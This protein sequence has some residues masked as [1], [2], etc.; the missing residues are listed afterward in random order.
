VRLRFQYTPDTEAPAE[1]NI[2]LP[3]RRLLCMAENCSSTLH[4][5]YTPRG[6]QIR[7]ALAWSKY[8]NESIELFGATTDIVFMSHHWPRFGNAAVVRFLAEQRDTYRWIHDETMRRANHGETASEIA[9]TLGPPPGLEDRAHIR[10]YYGTLS[11]NAKAVYQRYLG[12]FDANP[13]HLHPLPPVEAASRYVEFMGGIDA[14]VEKVQGSIAAG[15]YRWAAQVLDHAVFAAPD[16]TD[17]KLLQADV[18]E[19]LGY[20]AESGP[21]RDFYLTGAQELRHGAPHLGGSMA[22]SVDVLRAMTTEMLVDLIAVRLDGAAA[23]PVMVNLTITDRRDIGVVGIDHGA[24]R[25]TA[26]RHDAGAT[27]ALAVT[28]LGLARLASGQTSLDELGDEAT[29]SGD[30][31]ALDALIASLDRFDA[32]FA[33]VTP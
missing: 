24:V 26:G 25:F 16:R 13:A 15:E 8:I 23:A 5:V 33:I 21:W 10:G 3:D 18:L 31:A 19:Q 4:N 9:E 6:A 29:V 27:V 12:W 17:V 28:H 30:R 32:S 11:H 20:R 14:V 2:D 1:M 22:S 7:D